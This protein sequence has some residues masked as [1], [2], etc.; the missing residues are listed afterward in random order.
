MDSVLKTLTPEQ[1]NISNSE[2]TS[3]LSCRQ[4]YDFEFVRNLT[5]KQTGVP[6]AR[7]TLGHYA[8]EL[9]IKARL[10]GG[11][12]VEAYRASQ[13]AFTEAMSQGVTVDVVM[14]TKF[15]YDRYIDHHKGWPEFELL[16]TEERIDLKITDEITIAI[17]YDAMMREVRSGKRFIMDFK[18][19]YD[20]WSPQDHDTNLQMPK[21]IAVMNANGMEIHGGILEE[22]RTRKLGEEKSRD[23]K[24]LWRRTYYYPSIAKKRN[25]LKQHIAA[26]LEIMDYRA[27]SEEEREVRNIPVFN[28]HGACKFCNFVSLCASKVDGKDI[29]T[30]IEVDFTENTYGYNKTVPTALQDL[31]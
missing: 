14:E 3:W 1:R 8:F 20:F 22:V 6:L 24:N 29:T 12:H 13:A 30:D 2:V 9:Y 7:G 11:D 18:Y 28:K 17:R 4:K 19:T 27:L 10:N 25:S 5:P 16:G 31:I 26:S 15:L 21:Y 23:P